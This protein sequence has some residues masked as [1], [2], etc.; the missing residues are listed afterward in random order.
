MALLIHSCQVSER[1][2]SLKDYNNDVASLIGQSDNTGAALFGLLS[3]GDSATTLETDIDNGPLQG[4]GRELRRGKALSVPGQMDQ[5]QQNLLLALRMRRD[6]VATIA[7]EIEQALGTTDASDAIQQ[8]AG[9]TAR[10]Y[11]SDV[12][13]KDY[14]AP[15]IAA[16]LNAAKIGVGGADGESINGGQFLPAL[17]WLQ[18]SFI[19]TRLGAHVAVAGNVN[20]AAP[21]LHGH[22]LNSVSVGGAALQ[23]GA[24]NTL[25]AR[26]APTF[27]LNLTNGGNFDE[28]DVGCRVTVSGLSDVGTATISETTPGETT[29]CSVT[30]PKPPTP[31]TY[32]VTAE[33]VPVPGE[34]N[35][36]NNYLTFPITFQ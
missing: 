12:V 26:P 20:T 32:N 23:T 25:P 9:A 24:T 16:A 28:F 33:V 21:G 8:I 6:G 14:A 11:S 27:V 34:K 30:L 7:G 19:A 29:T 15:E 18:P 10:F 36:S 1:N 31:G 17:G 3:S 13:Y 22:E 2:S 5:A 4:A 35:V